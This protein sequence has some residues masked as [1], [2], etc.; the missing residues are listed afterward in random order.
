[1]EIRKIFNNS[2][3]KVNKDRLLLVNKYRLNIKIFI[4]KDS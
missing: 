2:I 3:V 1:M 4:K